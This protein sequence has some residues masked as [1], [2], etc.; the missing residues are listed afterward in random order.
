LP[1]ARLILCSLLWATGHSSCSTH[2]IFR[3]LSKVSYGV[4]QYS[5]QWFGDIC[6]SAPQCKWFDQ[7]LRS[8]CMLGTLSHFESK[9]PRI[10][11]RWLKLMS[12]QPYEAFI[13][14]IWSSKCSI[15]QS[16]APPSYTGFFALPSSFLKVIKT[17]LWSYMTHLHS[18]QHDAT[19]L[20]RTQHP[21]DHSNPHHT[22]PLSM[23]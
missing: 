19:L 16:G 15:T 6:I 11:K 22:M 4:P 8:I 12:D 2:A 5:I 14:N 17:T 3:H 7:L 21:C 13:I 1:Q 20:Q 9:Q 10:H 23:S 18:C